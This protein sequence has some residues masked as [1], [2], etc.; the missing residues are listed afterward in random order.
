MKKYEVVVKREILVSVTLEANSAEEA[1]SLYEM[2]YP[3]DL[4]DV[5][6]SSDIEP[7]RA[8]EVQVDDD[9]PYHL[10]GTQETEDSAKAYWMGEIAW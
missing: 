4:E 9:I 5:L 7:P 10:R 1:L 3:S 6:D 8:T 2:G